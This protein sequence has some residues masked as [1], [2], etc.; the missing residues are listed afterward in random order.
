LRGIGAIAWKELYVYFSSPMAYIIAAVFLALTGF[1]FVDSISGPLPPAS[2]RDVLS[3]S[4]FIFV[5]WSPLITMRLLAEERKLG[6]LELLL[7]SPIR[8]YEVVLGKFLASLVILAATVSLTGYYALLLFWFGS[9]DLGPML[10][11]YLGFLLYG[12]VT[13]AIGLLAS[14]FTSNQ[15]V[16]AVISSGAL[17]LLTF[18]DTTE[19]Y[20]TG[21]VGE[22]LAN[23]GVAAHFTD[24]V[25]GIIDTNNAVYYLSFTAFCLFLT[26]RNLEMRRWN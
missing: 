23:L 5:L 4:T 9:P 13:L 11:S 25:R 1:F 7:T 3:N 18:V 14:S 20:I 8:D 6:T 12:S 21:I 15:M 10:S 24:F 16:A 26:V 17:L 22:I 19:T 2:L